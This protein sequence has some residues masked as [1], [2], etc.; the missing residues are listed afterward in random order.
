M[1]LLHLFGGRRK[2]A[3]PPGRIAASSVLSGSASAWKAIPTGQSDRA[4]W[5]GYSMYPI[6]EPGTDRP[7]AQLCQGRVVSGACEHHQPDGGCLSE[8]PC[9]PGGC[10]SCLPPAMVAG[11]RRDRRRWRG[12]AAL[13]ILSPPSLGTRSGK[14]LVAGGYAWRREI[15]PK[16]RDRPVE[17]SV[18]NKGRFS[19]CSS[20]FS[21]CTSVFW[22][23]MRG[24]IGPE[25]SREA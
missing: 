23:R 12:A 16:W 2:Q 21:G 19:G 15:C 3:T 14:G 25:C 10:R 24:R 13:W 17:P 6:R 11:L 22:L 7:S 18:A 8:I 4:K 5:L 20:A 1:L 9:A